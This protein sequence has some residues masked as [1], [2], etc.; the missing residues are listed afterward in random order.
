VVEE[1]DCFTDIDPWLT[2]KG[3][4]LVFRRNS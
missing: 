3:L 1:C 2:L 4:E